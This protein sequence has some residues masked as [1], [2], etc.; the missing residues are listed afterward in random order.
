MA[1]LDFGLNDD[2][3]VKLWSKLLDREVFAQTHVARFLVK[4]TNGL[5]WNKD[6]LSTTAGD[7]IRVS[8]RLLLDG[9]GVTEDEV[10]EGQEEA[11]KFT[12]DNL[13]INE[14]AHGS[15]WHGTIAAQRVPWDLRSEARDALGDWYAEKL[16]QNFF[17]QIGGNSGETSLK[18]VGHNTAIAPTSTTGNTR[19]LIGP[20]SGQADAE[21]SLSST[22]SQS[23]QLPGIDRLVRLATTAK[24]IIKP[25]KVDGTGRW[26]MFLS[27]GQIE[28]LKTD[29]EA[30]S[31][32]IKWQEIH[33]SA[34]QGGQISDN[35]IF[36]GSIG[37]YNNTILHE[38]QRL[39][40]VSGSAGSVRRSVFCGKGAA[41]MGFG[42]ASPGF[43]RFDWNE[44]SFDHGR[45]KAVKVGA[46]YGVKKLQFVNR[47]G[48]TVDYGTIVHTTREPDL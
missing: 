29:I 7:R 18:R 45:Q 35:S 3:T 15:R 41:A 20:P 44:E 48:A 38:S 10:L 22:A 39:P 8:L 43:N 6:D 23:F 2:Q 25:V 36:Q 34:M 40:T 32:R 33:L 11:M 27:P 5:L 12:A 17:N 30:S 1:I 28:T 46:I 13:L 9:E 14:T 47:A 4:G 31:T 37:M 16:D 24:P 26:V 19:I 21:S 42:Q